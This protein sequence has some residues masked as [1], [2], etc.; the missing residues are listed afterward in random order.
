MRE[1]I[2]V[3]FIG[4][5]RVEVDDDDGGVDDDGLE[6][7]DGD[8]VL[9]AR[10]QWATCLRSTVACSGSRMR[11]RRASRLGSRWRRAPR[12]GM[13]QWCASGVGSRTV[14]GNSAAVSPFS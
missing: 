12:P 11:Q 10:G 5:R 14:G 3:T 8:G 6:V 13:R 9:W 7:G 2:G 1:G 4:G